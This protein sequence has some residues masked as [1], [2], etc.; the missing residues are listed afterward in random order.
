MIK[1]VLR[2]FVGSVDCR[3]Y[4][5]KCTFRCSYY[6]IAVCSNSDFLCNFKTIMIFLNSTS[7]YSFLL[8]TLLEKLS[9]PILS[10]LK[11]A[12]FIHLKTSSE[13]SLALQNAMKVRFFGI[14]PFSFS[15]IIFSQN[16]ITLFF[17]Y[18]TKI[19]IS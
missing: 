2:I 17:F 16:S 14:S 13:A 1:R 12:F 15:L 5:L 4:I 18:N 10:L 11:F 9:I 3:L 8:K 19:V 7:F 6:Y